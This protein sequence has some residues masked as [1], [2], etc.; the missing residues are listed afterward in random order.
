[1][2]CLNKYQLME[3]NN[4]IKNNSYGTYLEKVSNSSFINYNNFYTI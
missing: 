4:S 1:M 3:I 2:R